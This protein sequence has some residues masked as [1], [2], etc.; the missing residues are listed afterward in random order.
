MER[1]ATVTVLTVI[2]ALWCGLAPEAAAAAST[3]SEPGSG[4]VLDWEN[5]ADRILPDRPPSGWAAEYWPDIRHA[6][7]EPQVR[8]ADASR[9]EPVRAGAH[10]VRFELD[11]DDRPKNNGSRAEIGAEAPVEPPGAERWYGFST[12]L[13]Q[14]WGL[15]VAPEIIAQ[16]HQ[17][18]GDCSRGCSPPL[19]I[20]T[21]NGRYLLGQNWQNKSDV[22]GDWT[23]QQTD[24]GP[25]AIGRWTDWVVHVTWSTGN[26]GVLEVWKDGTPVPGFAHKVGR[27]D[28]FGERAQ[29]K[30]NYLVLGPYKWPWSQAGYQP[31]ST[32]TNRVLYAD[33]LRVADGRGSYA[34]VAPR[35]APASSTGPLA[36]GNPLQVTPGTATTA[37]SA[38]FTVVNNGDSAVTVPYFL[39]GARTASGSNADFPAGPA[40]TLQPGQTHTYQGNRALPPGS[41]TAWPAYYDGHTWHELGPHITVAVAS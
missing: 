32:T 23:F 13:P 31:A 35:G 28:D 12:Y 11:K 34:A 19:A 10:S 15:D 40:V 33:E 38:R 21:K 7:G 2:G 1:R 4:Y 37:T 24:I 9:G 3:P 30:G 29:G 8:A 14:S 5:A 41:Y 25:Y 20:V 22:P 27:N 36:V 18:G 6:D 39:V 26:D 17:T 16:W